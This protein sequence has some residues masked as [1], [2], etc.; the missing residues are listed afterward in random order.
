LPAFALRVSSNG[1]KGSGRL[2]CTPCSR[3]GKRDCRG[4]LFAQSPSCSFVPK[5]LLILEFQIPER[6]HK[7]VLKVVNGESG[8]G[9]HERLR[10]VSQGSCGRLLWVRQR[11][12]LIGCKGLTTLSVCRGCTQWGAGGGMRRA[13]V[14]D[15]RM[16]TNG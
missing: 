14:G 7:A 16:G 12:D 3:V 10:W 15:L 5:R 11:C 9:G 13:R 1:V 6:V 8:V 2:C 4:T